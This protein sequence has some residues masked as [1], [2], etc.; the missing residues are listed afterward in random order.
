M[1]H[2]KNGF[3]ML[4]HPQTRASFSVPYR[5]T[6]FLNNNHTESSQRISRFAFTCSPAL[7]LLRLALLEALLSD[8]LPAGR[9][10]RGYR[11]IPDRYSQ[12]LSSEFKASS[13]HSGSAANF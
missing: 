11:L 5:K 13:N 2:S 10:C 4:G 6:L 3:N 12:P 7:L 8:P 1:H 9:A